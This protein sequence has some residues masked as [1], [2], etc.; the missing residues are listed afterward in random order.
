MKSLEHFSEK[1]L[2]LLHEN[3]LLVPLLKAEY[4]KELTNSIQISKEDIEKY[5]EIFKANRK[6][7][8]D[9]IF[10]KW[11]ISNKTTKSSLISEIVTSLRVA[12]FSNQ[13]FSH[14]V[15]S[16]FL[17]KKYSLDK[18]IYSLLRVKDFY[19]AR[20]LKFRIAAGEAQFG[21]LAS[22][23][24]CGFEKDTLG[25]VGPVPLNSGHPIIVETLKT[26]KKGQLNGPFKVD[27]WNVLVRLESYQDAKLD[28]NTKIQLKK[29]MFEEF[30]SQQIESKLNAIIKATL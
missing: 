3:K 25:I 5:L 18:V 10:E 23:Y 14:K 4:V 19:F 9:S 16:R 24:S 26:S 1:N 17:E 2:L 29:Q 21:Q 30:V 28:E 11:L 27:E 20:E 7:L 6:L 22:Q 13:K 15:E 8:D 12:E